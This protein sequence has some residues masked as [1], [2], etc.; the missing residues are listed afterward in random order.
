LKGAALFLHQLLSL[1][2]LLL[3][4]LLARCYRRRQLGLQLPQAR[5][6]AALG[7]LL[8]LRRR[9]SRHRRCCHPWFLLRRIRWMIP[10]RRWKIPGSACSTAQRRP[11][12][13]PIAS[14]DGAV[15]SFNAHTKRAQQLPHQV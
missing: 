1:L 4:A 9:T 15:A 12:S 7:G 13:C 10:M 2:R 3:L 6:N 8:L 14:G 5:H 11:P